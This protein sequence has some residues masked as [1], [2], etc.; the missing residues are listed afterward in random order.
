MIENIEK[1]K[2]KLLEEKARIE[3]EIASVSGQTSVVDEST[4]ADPN[5]VA[6]KIEEFDTNFAIADDLK[7]SLNDVQAALSKIDA[8]TYGVC[9]VSGEP[10]ELDR[11]EANPAA[12]TCKEHM[13]E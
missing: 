6:D 8:G 12:R 1:F 2:E 7:L 9:E 3:K 5:E 11:L 4:D 13:N 10:I